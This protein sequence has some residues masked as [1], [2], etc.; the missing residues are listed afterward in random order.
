MSYDSAHLWVIVLRVLPT[1]PAF[2]STFLNLAL[3]SVIQA[4][5]P[6][7]WKINFKGPYAVN[8]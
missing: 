4:K 8:C 7:Y 3:S 6:L 5:R 1:I 2:L